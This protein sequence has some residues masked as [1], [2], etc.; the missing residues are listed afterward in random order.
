MNVTNADGGGA[1]LVHESLPWAEILSASGELDLAVA[2]QF[3]SA[4]DTLLGGNL[5]VV[6]DLSG[7]SYLDSTIL[8]VLVGACNAAPNR[9]AIVVPPRARIRRVFQ[10][11]GLDGALLIGESREKL[12]DHFSTKIS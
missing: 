9:F 5:P 8:R 4:L 7:C 1:I 2:P 6:V 10:I 11:A 12:R 3:G